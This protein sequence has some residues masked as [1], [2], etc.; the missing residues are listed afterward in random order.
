M[1]FGRMKKGTEKAEIIKK[2]LKKLSIDTLLEMILYG[3]RQH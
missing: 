3:E 1:L 2:D